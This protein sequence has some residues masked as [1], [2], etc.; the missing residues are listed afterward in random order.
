MPAEDGVTE[1][2]E[3][4]DFVVRR[5]EHGI[6]ARRM[7]S[8]RCA[9]TCS[10]RPDSQAFGV[11][12]A[13]RAIGLT[14]TR[15]PRRSPK[16]CSRVAASVKARHRGH[17]ADPA[18]W[19]RRAHLRPSTRTSSVAIPSSLPRSAPAASTASTR[20]LHAFGDEWQRFPELLEVHQRIFDWYFEGPEPVRWKGLRVLDAGC[21]MGRWLHFALG[22]R[23]G[24][25]RDG[26]QPRDR[27]GRGA[28]RGRCRLRPGRPALATIPAGE[29]RSRL[30]ASASSITW[31]TAGRRPGAGEAGAAGRGAAALRLPNAR[32]RALVETGL[33]AAVTG[34]RRITTRLPYPAV[35]AVSWLVAAVATVCFLWPRRLLRRW[36]WG[37]RLTRRLPLVHYTDV[38]FRMVVSEQFDRLVAPIEGRFSRQEVEGWLRD[39]GFE[40]VAILPGLGWR[41]IGQ[42]PGRPLP[43]APPRGM[44]RRPA[45]APGGGDRGPPPSGRGR[46]PL[47]ER[48]AAAASRGGPRP[49]RGRGAV[50]GVPSRRSRARSVGGRCASRRWRGPGWPGPSAARSRGWRGR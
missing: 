38:P 32:G 35:H 15:A 45:P 3:D 29:L 12:P 48:R 31:R 22:R 20:T 10:V 30:L 39:V 9:R 27:R 25:R 46:I 13:A 28:G 40:V 24:D 16:V 42:T 50:A 5:S 19:R 41:A 26:R 1:T 17:S 21:G 2:I 7:T 49:A 4:H 47:R 37:D 18:G 11:P 36:G 6:V 44:T 23:G 34:L 33:F 8:R 14:S 43:N